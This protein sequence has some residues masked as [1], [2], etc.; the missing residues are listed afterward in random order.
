MATPAKSL[1]DLGL[2]AQAGRDALI[3][4]IAVD[5]RQVKPGFLFA[6]LPGSTVHDAEFIQYSLR[7]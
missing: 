6:A 3:T 7:L 5:S 1:A 4:G 2:R